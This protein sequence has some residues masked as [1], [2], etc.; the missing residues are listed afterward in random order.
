MERLIT[1][2]GTGNASFEQVSLAYLG[3]VT[4]DVEILVG[5][6][7]YSGTV[8]AV[9][10]LWGYT[11][12]GW[13]T[14]LASVPE[15]LKRSRLSYDELLQLLE[16]PFVQAAGQFGVDFSD[17][18]SICDLDGAVLRYIDIVNGGFDATQ[19]LSKETFDRIQRFLRLLRKTGWSIWEL[20][21]VL[22][23][24][25]Q[26]QLTVTTFDYLNNN[27]REYEITKHVSLA[28]LDP[29]ALLN[30]TT[31]GECAFSIP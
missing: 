5:A 22:A 25:A 27:R 21:R 15:F 24:L 16:A 12:P 7:A 3:L 30:L 1:L 9:G 6:P 29:V 31:M 14:S 17:V 23:V 13:R 20:G 26:P 19:L 8:A 28:A 11:A 2:P 4:T 10:Q 18:E